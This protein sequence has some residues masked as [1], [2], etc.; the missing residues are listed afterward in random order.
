MKKKISGENEAKKVT[1]GQIVF[2]IIIAGST[3]G[4]IYM[5]IRKYKME[6]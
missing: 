5:L 1:V 3:A 6:R 2:I 4:V